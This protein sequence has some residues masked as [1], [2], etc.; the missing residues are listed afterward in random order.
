MMPVGDIAGG[1]PGGQAN[2]GDDVGNVDNYTQEDMG[3]SSVFTGTVA[4]AYSELTEMFNK[5]VAAG[6]DEGVIV[7][8]LAIMANNPAEV[9]AAKK[10]ARGLVILDFLMNHAE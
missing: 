6:T 9:Y 7:E 4:D 8:Q 1:I 5:T 2:N 3:H 10:V